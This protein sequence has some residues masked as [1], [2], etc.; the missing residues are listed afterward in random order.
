VEVYRCF[1]PT[2]VLAHAPSDYHPDHRAAS[3]LAE[4][5][6]WF[7]AS[8]GHRTESPALSSP[9]ALWWM[10]TVNMIDF[11]PHFYVDISQY[12]ELKRRM[13]ACHR[14]Q[15]QRGQD[16]DFSPLEPLML[17]QCEVRGDQ[18]SAG[19]AE[20]FRWHAAWKRTRAW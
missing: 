6:T 1:R 20:A 12:V 3:L 13:L 15:L 17:R 19:A 7:A 4:A 14:S 2:L 18:A 5:A 16:A 11:T 9:P 8:T 10:D